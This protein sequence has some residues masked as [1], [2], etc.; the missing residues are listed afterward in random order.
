MPS[1]AEGFGLP[2][3]EAMSLGAPVVATTVPALVEVAG[4]AAQ[5]AEPDA[6]RPRRGASR[7]WSTTRELAFAT[8]PLA[9]L[10]RAAEFDWDAPADGS[11]CC[12][13]NSCTDSVRSVVTRSIAAGA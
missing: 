13:P 2:V 7:P 9:G 5:L 1:R 10:V 3:L 4:G 11:G 8:W 12:T 6:G